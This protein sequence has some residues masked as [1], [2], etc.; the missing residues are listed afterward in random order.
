MKTEK[1]EQ[2]VLDSMK[3]LPPQALAEVADFAEFLKQRGRKRRSL[4]GTLSELSRAE[5]AHL[6]EEFRDYDKRYPTE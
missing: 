2:L 5:E 1:P 4:A 6:E 3:G